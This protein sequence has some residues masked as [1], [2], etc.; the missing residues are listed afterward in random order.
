MDI[1]ENNWVIL[2]VEELET[3]NVL[4][5]AEYRNWCAVDNSLDIFLS[6]NSGS[7]KVAAGQQQQ[8]LFIYGSKYVFV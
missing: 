5:A 8:H 3:I 7:F 2:P 1:N 4:S 6:W